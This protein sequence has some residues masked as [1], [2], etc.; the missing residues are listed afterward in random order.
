M[1][2]GKPQGPMPSR[3]T[4]RSSFRPPVIM[5]EFRPELCT[6]TVIERQGRRV[7]PFENLV[8]GYTCRG[9]VEPYTGFTSRSRHVQRTWGRTHLGQYRM[10]PITGAVI[11]VV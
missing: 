11:M 2:F 3:R 8:A 7:R 1:G 4:W 10:L 6:S 9:T 5:S